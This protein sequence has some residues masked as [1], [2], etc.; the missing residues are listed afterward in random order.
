MRIAL[1]VPGLRRHDAVSNDCL[2]MAAVL[3]A[4]GHEVRVFT[5]SADG[6][7]EAVGD[8]TELPGWLTSPR[9]VVI[10]HFCTGWDLAVDLLAR[11]RAVRVV[12]YHNITPAGFF[13]GWSRGYEE[14][15]ER[16]RKQIV[17]LARMRCE[18]YLGCSP[19]NLEDFTACGVDASS[20][21]V[22]P[23]F[24][25]CE[26]LVAE[27][28]DTSKLP[29]TGGAPLLLMVGRLAPNKGYLEL[30]DALDACRVAVDDDAHLLVLG[31]L[32]PNLA[33]YG[34]AVHARVAELG[35]G[36]NV[37]FIDDAR[38]PDLRAAFDAA[39]ALVMLSAHEGFC[40]P[41]IE[42]FALG[43]PVVAYASSAVPW[44]LG[45]AGLLWDER[46]PALIASSIARL[47]RDEP[48]RDALVDAGRARYRD[49][50]APDVLARDLAVVVERLS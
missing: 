23:P 16:G 12:R 37:T 29:D 30:V 35:L 41:V 27:I 32:D 36:R 26:A 38:G 46:D 13:R 1:L 47:H 15:C 43:T 25:E 28:P 2:H 45:G 33:A 50:F 40:V 4:Q 10:Y 49:V 19:F 44:T 48:V 22:L 21:A 9:D 39:T 42:A 24:H 14:A 18:L 6:V 17:R 34:E 11:V 8:P 31:K 5:L 3:R 7:D 20:C